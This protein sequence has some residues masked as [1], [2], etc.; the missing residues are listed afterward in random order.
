MSSGFAINPISPAAGWLSW[1]SIKALDR[2]NDILNCIAVQ[3]IVIE[4]GLDK[5]GAHAL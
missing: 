3:S 4:V 1:Q 5:E 2:R